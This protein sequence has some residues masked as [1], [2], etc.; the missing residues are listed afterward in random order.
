[1][2]WTSGAEGIRTVIVRRARVSGEV[3]GLAGWELCGIR[4]LRSSDCKRFGRGP[5]R[6]QSEGRTHGADRW[7]VENEKPWPPVSEGPCGRQEGP[8]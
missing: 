3:W 7:E 6:E 5:E 1:M 2:D 4:C 8:E